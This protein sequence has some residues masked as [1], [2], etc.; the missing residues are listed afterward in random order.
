MAQNRVGGVVVAPIF[1]VVDHE[2]KIARSRLALDQNVLQ[3]KNLS[4]SF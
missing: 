1:A 2:R 3:T 4:I